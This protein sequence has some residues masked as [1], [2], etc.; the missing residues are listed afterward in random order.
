MTKSTKTGRIELRTER[1]RESRI[2]FAAELSHQSLSAFILDAASSRAEDVIASASV[3][4]VPSHF[5]D[6]LWSSLDSPPRPNSALARR[7]RAKRRV[8]QKGA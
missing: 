1:S 2:R 8:A 5:F 3:T 7:A 4:A 6:K